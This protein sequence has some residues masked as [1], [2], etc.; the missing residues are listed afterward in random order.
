MKKRLLLL[1]LCLTLFTGCKKEEE[2]KPITLIGIW[3]DNDEKERTFQKFNENGTGEDWIVKDGVKGKSDKF[4]Y[5]HNK[6]ESVITFSYLDKTVIDMLVLDFTQKKLV[7]Q[8]E[9]N[10]PI[11]FYKQ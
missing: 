7:L 1:T 10:E 8:Y 2:E 3:A 9:E 4:N 6:E 11:T 5:F